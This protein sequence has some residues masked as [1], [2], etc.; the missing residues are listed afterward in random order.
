MH[1]NKFL[2]LNQACSALF[3]QNQSAHTPS[4]YWL[5]HKHFDLVLDL[6]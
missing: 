2:A 5:F 1:K 4:L 3:P 6:L